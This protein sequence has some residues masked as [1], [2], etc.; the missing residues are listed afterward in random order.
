MIISIITA[1][2]NSEATIG[3]TLECIDRQDYYSIE[4]IIVDGECTDSTLKTVRGF[5][6][7]RKIIS[8]KDNGIYD[9]MNKGISAASG[10]IIG[11]LNSDD[12]YINDHVLSMV[13]GVFE[14]NQ[15]D[16]CYADLQ[17]VRAGDLNKVVRTWKSGQ[18]T[19]RA[20]YWGWMPP[21]PT[22]FVR[23]S[24]YQKVGLF[25]TD[26][27]SASDYEMMLRILLRYELSAHYI[28]QVIVKMRTGGVSNASILNRIRANSEDRLAW[29]VNGLQP[30]FF[31][32]YVKPLRKISQFLNR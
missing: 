25:N 29:K 2:H 17:Y 21:H 10:E 32:L 12:V 27:K 3:H 6:H 14:N 15:V 8:E 5:S 11:I 24:I 4:H 28:P 23:K 18:F 9:A 13:A 16:V 7:V 20:F 31:T 19:R 30:Y 26:L 1:T 22:F